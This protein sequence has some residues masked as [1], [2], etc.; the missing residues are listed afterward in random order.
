MPKQYPLLATA[1]EIRTIARRAIT[2]M[3]VLHEGHDDDTAWNDPDAQRLDN[4]V[5]RGAKEAMRFCATAAGLLGDAS[6]LQLVATL[7]E[8]QGGWDDHADKDTDVVAEG[9]G[10]LLRRGAPVNDSVAAF[11]ASPNDDIRAVI[12]AGLRPTNERAIKLLE[13]LAKD[14]IADVRKPAQEALASRGE[15]HWWAGKWQRDPLAHL[16]AADA[17]AL[18]E[19]IERI[20]AMLDESRWA[21][22]KQDREFTELVAKLPDPIAVDVLETTLAS[23]GNHDTRMPL[24]GAHLLSRKGGIEAFLRVLSGWAKARAFHLTPDHK[25][26][27]ATLPHDRAVVVGLALAKYALSAPAS[28]RDEVSTAYFLAAELV[29][30]VMPPGADLAPIVELVL[31]AP[32]TASRMDFIMNKIANVLG[33]KNARPGALSERLLAARLAGYPGAWSRMA[34]NID[35]LLQKAPFE[36]LR[37]AVEQALRSDDDKLTRWA[38]RCILTDAHAAE[39]DGSRLELAARL[40]EDTRL[41]GLL[42]ADSSLTKM[43]IT[44]LRAALRRGELA[45][46]EALNVVSAISEL[47]GGVAPMFF[48]RALTSAGKEEARQ[49]AR[50]EHAPFLGPEELSGPVT[51]DEWTALRRAREANTSHEYGDW[52]RILSVLP[53]GPWHP[54]DHALLDRALAA[55]EE[56]PELAMPI[57]MC[58]TAKATVDDLPIF[59]RLIERAPD[60]R[61]L[62]RSNLYSTRERLGLPKKPADDTAKAEAT[63]GGDW[64]DEDDDA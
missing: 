61:A 49:K 51:E 20:S 42:V 60:H 22:M 64:M 34:G 55:F 4:L 16:P 54:E 9:L 59:D 24:T 45:C 11:A 13:T 6:L 47:W 53:E 14:P 52:M 8:E 36:Q 3:E 56:H 25:A 58:L 29:E 50:A 28:V 41:R 23:G 63:S 12:A 15:L 40:C 48:S 33:A 46:M 2:L 17:E 38:L 26:M 39:T 43:A 19:P 35:K 5:F 31:E 57:S 32:E 18:R 7:L 44:P 62:V 37:P 1:E 21:L 30:E 10:E 27:V